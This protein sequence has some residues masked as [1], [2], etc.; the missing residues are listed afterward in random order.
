MRRIRGGIR[1]S[2][3]M[4]RAPIPAFA[5]FAADSLANV[6]LEKEHKKTW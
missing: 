1:V 5:S 3:W 6:G 2:G 4:V